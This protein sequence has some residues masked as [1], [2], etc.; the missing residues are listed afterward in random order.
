MLKVVQAGLNIDR[1]PTHFFC[2]VADRKST[3]EL[4][5]NR[6]ESR[7][8]SSICKTLTHKNMPRE[9]NGLGWT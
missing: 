4:K 3:K 1:I 5:Y 8:P 7:T 6:L 9:V 2:N